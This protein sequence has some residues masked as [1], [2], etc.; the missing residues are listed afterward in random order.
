MEPAFRALETASRCV[1]DVKEQFDGRP[2]SDVNMVSAQQQLA[3]EAQ[4]RATLSRYELTPPPGTH[5]ILSVPGRYSLTRALKPDE[6]GYSPSPVV[7]ASRRKSTASRLD[8]AVSDLPPPPSLSRSPQCT[9][10]SFAPR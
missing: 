7:Q 8:R 9:R 1:A 3:L 4:W 10:M 6:L 2:A 5:L